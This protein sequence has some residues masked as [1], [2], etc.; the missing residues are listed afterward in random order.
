MTQ[1][2]SDKCPQPSLLIEFLQG[3]LEPPALDECE[4]HLEQCAQCHETL[5][6][7]DSDDTLSEKVAAALISEDPG[8]N[9]DSLEIDGLITRLTSTEFQTRSPIASQLASSE[10]MAD[11]AAEVLRCVEPDD[12]TLG[13]VGDY[14]LLRLIGSGSTGVVFQALDRTLERTVALKVLRPSLGV[15]ARDRFLAEARSAASIEH[16]NVVTIFQVGQVDRL[17]FI[18]MQWLPGETLEAKLQS[19]VSLDES[20]IADTVLKVASGLA[21]AHQRQLVHRDIKPANLWICDTDQQLKILDFGL[22][23]INDDNPGLTATGMLAGTPNFMSPEQA[24]GHELDGRSDLFSV[25]CLMYQLLT[26]R[27]PFGASTILG[28][29]QSVQNE[30]PI[31]PRQIKP[32]VPQHLSDLTMCLLEK[33]PANRPESANQLIEMLSSPREDWPI[34]VN[35][36]L[37]SPEEKPEAVHAVSNKKARQSSGMRWLMTGLLLGLAGWGAWLWSPQIIRV[38]TDQGEVVIESKA[39]DVE[40]QVFA[41]GELIRVVDTQTQ[42][43]FD[44]KSGKYTFAA[45]SSVDGENTF[46]ISPKQ[47]TMSRGSTQIVTVK[48]EDRAAKVTV[49]DTKKIYA[50]RVYLKTYPIATDPEIALNVIR[51][52]LDGTDATLGQDGVSGAIVLR[53]REQHHK[54]VQE[55]I[56]TLQGNS[57]NTR[58]VQQSKSKGSSPKS[59]EEVKV[60]KP[61]YSEPV[62]DGETFEH[63]INVAEHDRSENTSIRALAAAT[64]IAESKGQ[65]AKVAQ[66]IRVLLRKKSAFSIEEP[67]WTRRKSTKQFQLILKDS[68]GKV[69]ADEVLKLIDTEIRD[70]TEG[71]RSFL[72]YWIYSSSRWYWL[73]RAERPWTEKKP[74]WKA[75]LKNSVRF[76]EQAANSQQPGN[77]AIADAFVW[78]ASENGD[79]A[80]VLEKAHE[81]GFTQQL[82]KQLASGDLR[83]RLEKL[84]VAKVLL[85]SNEAVYEMYEDHFFSDKNRNRQGRAFIFEEFIC[86][87]ELLGKLSHKRALTLLKDEMDSSFRRLTFRYLIKLRPYLSEEFIRNE[88]EPKLENVDLMKYMALEERDQLLP[89]RDKAPTPVN[90]AANE[91]RSKSTPARSSLPSRDKPIFKNQTFEQWLQVAKRDR[92]AATRSGALEACAATAETDAEKE[93]LIALTRKICRQ[94]GGNT[95]GLN[96]DDDLYYNALA[97]VLVSLD[98]N[99]IVKFI[100]MEIAAGTEASR[101]FCCGWLVGLAN[102]SASKEWRSKI[103]SV[104]EKAGPIEDALASHL[105]APGNSLILQSLAYSSIKDNFKDTKL[106]K[107]LKQS[108]ANPDQRLL[109]HKSI[110]VLLGDDLEMFQ[111][112][113]EDLLNPQTD[114][115]TREKFFNSLLHNN[116][117]QRPL[118][119]QWQQLLFDVAKGVLRQGDQRLEFATD[120]RYGGGGG[121]DFREDGRLKAEYVLTNVLLGLNRLEPQLEAKFKTETLLPKLK[122]LKKAVEMAAKDPQ[123]AGDFI[124]ANIKILLADFDYLIKKASGDSDAEMPENSFLKRGAFGGGVF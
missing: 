6:G 39:D 78:L 116:N 73:R 53:G 34:G 81:I 119:R 80:K 32:D 76:F 21:A 4:A 69:G 70:G 100:E 33:Q 17:A 121:G 38:M 85:G 62:Y 88:L 75:V 117:Q 18:A 60:A 67:R 105:E 106:A 54:I 97:Q 40:I 49:L 63:W 74:L 22:A 56:A 93:P 45:R 3:K 109:L 91:G 111:L 115:E 123:R 8:Q 29:L 95:L 2:P 44:L 66:V 41:D 37:G 36:Y 103:A 42:Q 65:K 92:D 23:R 26:G 82:E 1:F 68:M 110:V 43:S 124:D 83:L 120:L 31:P 20:Q 5:R 86:S 59:D 79:Q 28:T 118:P 24:R 61:P 48:T 87:E 58:V 30:S 7:L 19:G 108:A 90:T 9:S 98:T 94:Y 46:A 84:R 102:D 52:M 13:L 99:Q 15:V 89:P 25:G 96:S 104:T 71:S 16:A 51:T 11:R 112:L 47:L 77:E 35:Q 72:V 55:T 27:L 50:E 14:A 64:A 114:P 107:A 113:R 122:E 57:D 101:K 10:I 12:E